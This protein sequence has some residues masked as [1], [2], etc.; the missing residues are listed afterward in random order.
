[1][2]TLYY[3]PYT[4]EPIKDGEMP[5]YDAVE[6]KLPEY[7]YIFNDPQAAQP[8]ADPPRATHPARPTA[9]TQPPLRNAR[10]VTDL[11]QTSLSVMD[12]QMREMDHYRQAVGRMVQDLLSLRAQVRG[13]ETA[14][15]Q[16]RLQLSNFDNTTRVILDSVDIDGLPKAEI[17]S[18]YA[19]LKQTLSSQTSELNHYKDKV[20][21][22]QNE[23]IKKNDKEKE[24]LRMSHAHASQQKLLQKLQDKMHK[25]RQLEDTC[26]KQ[27]KVI[28][29][30]ELILEKQRRKTGNTKDTS[31]DAN[32]A[33]TQE[34]R[35]LRE[36]MDSLREQARKG[37]GAG[38]GDSDAGDMEKLEL[39]QALERAEG[40]TMSLERQMLENS[41][42]WGKE[43]ASLQL[44]LTDH[45]PSVTTK[46]G[47]LVLRDFP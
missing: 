41:R 9:G 8:S 31:S 5:A 18:R 17:A 12:Q 30:M 15:S 47:G 14:N 45:K 44:Q 40:R 39:Y 10:I 46:L 25:V 42:Q 7:Q 26:R 37:K 29:K 36:E 20:Q 35:R 34:N 3:R 21:K 11:D 2:A 27:E 6:S 22:L 23:L 16:L 19:T 13:L 1:M 33:L 28:E 43:R 38:G 24:F 32:A 4:T